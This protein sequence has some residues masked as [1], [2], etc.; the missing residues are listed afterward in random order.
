MDDTTAGS[1]C[2]WWPWL[3]GCCH[4]RLLGRYPLQRTGSGRL[5]FLLLSQCRLQWIGFR[6]RRSL[7]RRWSAPRIQVFTLL[8]LLQVFAVPRGRFRCFHQMV[9][10]R[11]LGWLLLL[12]RIWLMVVQVRGASVLQQLLRLLRYYWVRLMLMLLLL[13]SA[14]MLRQLLRLRLLLLDVIDEMWLLGTGGTV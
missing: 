9:R 1:R 11:L 13:Q 5:L 14:R 2:S 8:L 4:R 10:V 7:R 6:C 12:H 3:I